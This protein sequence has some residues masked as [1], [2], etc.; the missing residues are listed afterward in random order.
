MTYRVIR[1]AGRRCAAPGC[2]TVLSVY[3]SDHLCFTHADE[4]TRAPF[5]R[6]AASSRIDHPSTPPDIHGLRL[7]EPAVLAQHGGNS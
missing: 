2:P 5:E 3:N 7:L 1:D 4:K 6:R